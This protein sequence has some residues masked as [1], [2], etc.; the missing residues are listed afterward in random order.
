[1][2]EAE[3]KARAAAFVLVVFLMLIVCVIDHHRGLD[4]SQG[5]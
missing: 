3:K 1:M 2:S 4:S 5:E